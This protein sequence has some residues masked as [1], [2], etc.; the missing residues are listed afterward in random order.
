[1]I[2]LEN[3]SVKLMNLDDDEKYTGELN[4]ECVVQLDKD[5]N[6]YLMRH[7]PESFY[8]RK[9]VDDLMCIYPE[10]VESFPLFIRNNKKLMKNFLMDN[11]SFY[12]YLGHELQFDFDFLKSILKELHEYSLRDYVRNPEVQ[13]IL[14]DGDNTF[15]L[16]K[17][18]PDLFS[19]INRHLKDD[20]WE[21]TVKRLLARK[22][23]YEV[24][25][26]NFNKIK[27]VNIC[28]KAVEK[29]IVAFANLTPEQKDNVRVLSAALNNEGIEYNQDIRNEVFKRLKFNKIKDINVLMRTLEVDLE[30]FN[31][32]TEEQKNKI[33]VFFTVLNHEK[34]KRHYSIKENVLNRLWRGL[35]NNRFSVKDIIASATDKDINIEIWNLFNSN[36]D[37][38]KLC[39]QAQVDP[40]EYKESFKEA[41]RYIEL[42]AKINEDPEIMN[43]KN[44]LAKRK[45]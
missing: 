24:S 41:Y 1:M 10:S 26:I 22:D 7:F 3:L 45:I 9:M 23:F 15:Q 37:F 38:V 19:I 4:W 29:D 32:F 12:C 6:L 8:S 34:I 31:L 27:N 2:D 44:V 30:A 16:I 11:P 25:G 35:E 40:S 43:R 5:R 14:R 17:K 20:E 18:Y 36:K 42:K 39:T 33:E 21:V 28:I 13:D